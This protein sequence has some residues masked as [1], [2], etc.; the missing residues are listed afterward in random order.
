MGIVLT[1]STESTKNIIS[2]FAGK[3]VLDLGCGAG[4]LGI[5][6]LNAGANVHFQDYVK[7]IDLPLEKFK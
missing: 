1:K 7:I 3:T 2:E 4:V 6:A 5:L